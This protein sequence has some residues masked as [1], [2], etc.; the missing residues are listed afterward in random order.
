MIRTPENSTTTCGEEVT[1][2][3]PAGAPGPI[4][5]TT[6]QHTCY[7]V[8]KP[9]ERA[10]GFVRPVRNSYKHVGIRPKHELRDLTPE[11]HE[12]Y[13]AYGYVKYETYPEGD[14]TV[15]RY[16]TK[17]QLESGCGAVTTMNL[18]LSETYARDPSYYGSTFCCGCRGHL[19]VGEHGEF[20][21]TADGT[22]VGT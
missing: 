1:A 2:D 8:L 14:S 3:S 22:K 18:A 13:D 4:D 16:W 12:R 19:P 17:A 9:E 7:Y 6:G 15:G 20:V 11:E 10:K 21:W 5:P